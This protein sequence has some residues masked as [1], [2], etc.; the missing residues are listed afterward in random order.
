MPE[1]TELHHFVSKVYLRAFVDPELVKKSK[2]QVWVY[3]RGANPE[4]MGV[5]RVAAVDRYYSVGEPGRERKVEDWFSHMES[6]CAPILKK[7][8]TGHIAISPGEKADFSTFV[9]TAMA[10]VPASRKLIDITEIEKFRA[11]TLDVVENA[12]ALKL[13]FAHLKAQ[14]K[15][16]EEFMY[17]AE[18]V[19]TGEL[20]ADPPSQERNI[21]RI[22]ETVEQWRQFFGGMA[23]GLCIAPERSQFITSDNP[24]RVQD[25]QAMKAGP[26]AYKGP[27]SDLLLSFPLSPA[28]GL[29]GEFVS[30]QDQ[31][32]KVDDA[33]VKQSN[34]AQIYRAHQEVYASYYSRELQDQV[35]DIFSKRKPRLVDTYFR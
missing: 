31:Q 8:R 25:V 15:T 13:V 21:S 5:R 6:V 3:R 9:A 24:V 35:D 1:D 4:A 27:T 19:I 12:E 29:H 10:R 30:F 2:H 34:V 32:M 22:F 33:W 18:Q 28:C 17:Y 14:G 11:D 20:R 23:W 16:P 7:L 26:D